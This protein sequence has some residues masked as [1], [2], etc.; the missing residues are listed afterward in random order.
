MI[1]EPKPQRL[2]SPSSLSGSGLDGVRRRRPGKAADLRDRAARL[3][4]QFNEQFWLPDKGY[5]AVE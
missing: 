4:R 2:T 3:K 1:S 5:Y